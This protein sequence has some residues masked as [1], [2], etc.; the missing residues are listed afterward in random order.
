MGG[1]CAVGRIDQALSARHWKVKLVGGTGRDGSGQSGG[2]VPTCKGLTLRG[3]EADGTVP[4][5]WRPGSRRVGDSVWPR[6][7]APQSVRFVGNSG[8]G[9]VL[10]HGG[11]LRL[12]GA[13]PCSKPLIEHS[14]HGVEQTGRRREESREK[15][16]PL[17]F[18]LS[19]AGRVEFGDRNPRCSVLGGRRPYP[20]CSLDS[21]NQENP[22]VGE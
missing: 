2:A 18:Q 20:S 19:V 22:N 12:C 5:A 10:D 21:A 16:P 4:E 11:I 8:G 14:R 9:R 1:R 6:R 13:P 15:A 3:S 17:G 7:R